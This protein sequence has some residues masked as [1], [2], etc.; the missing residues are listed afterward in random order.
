MTFA[1]QLEADDVGANFGDSGV[2]YAFTCPHGA[3]FTWQ[4]A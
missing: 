1:L 2:G 3:K 4:C